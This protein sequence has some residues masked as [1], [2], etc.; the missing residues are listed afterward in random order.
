MNHK[1][2]KITVKNTQQ[3]SSNFTSDIVQIKANELASVPP[4]IIGLYHIETSPLISSTN[5]WIGF[6]MIRTVVMKESIR[7]TSLDA[8]FCDDSLMEAEIEQLQWR[9]FKIRLSQ[10]SD[11]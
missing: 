4:E 7:L 6:Y 5:Q 11:L 2:H 9:N 1:I 3:L 8:N 10:V